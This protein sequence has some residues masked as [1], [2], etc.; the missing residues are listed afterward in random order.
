MVG[1]IAGLSTLKGL[2][3][4][5]ATLTFAGF[6]AYFM[7]Q[8]VVAQAGQPP[9]LNTAMVAAAAALAGILGS[10]FALVIGAPTTVTNHALAGELVKKSN[11]RR[12][13]L[14]VWRVLSLE[15]G[16][17]ARASIPLTFGIWMYAIIAGAVAII[18]FTNQAETPEAIKALATVFAGY[19][20]A[21]MTAAYGLATG[22]GSTA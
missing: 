1:R 18:Y 17:E 16:G 21:L 3:V 2:V 7:D 11:E 15:P 19:V 8:I 6:Y 20:V 14:W 13:G 5:G 12:R 10:A 22:S 9:K 4:Y